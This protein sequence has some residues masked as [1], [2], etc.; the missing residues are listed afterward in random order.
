[1]SSSRLAIF[2]IFFSYYVL[3]TYI[4]LFAQTAFHTSEILA[5]YLL[6]IANAGSLVG[7][8]VPYLLGSK[9]PPIRLFVLWSIA[10][11]ALL[12]G[13]IGITTLAGFIV[14]CPVGIRIWGTCDCNDCRD[15]S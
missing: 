1:M 4:P 15:I 6:A 7:R 9:V 5:G 2:L 14:W 11:V 10:S 3:F 8:I 12:F 13:W